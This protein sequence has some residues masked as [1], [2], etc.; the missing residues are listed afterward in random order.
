MLL[1]LLLLYYPTAVNQCHLLLVDE[2]KMF[3]R[4][5]S[6]FLCSFAAIYRVATEEEA[7]AA[8]GMF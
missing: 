8:E 4:C 3:V 6:C 5:C 2:E 1:L 7:M